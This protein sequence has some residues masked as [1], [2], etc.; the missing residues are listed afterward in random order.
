M[1]HES[2]PTHLHIARDGATLGEFDVDTVRS[3]VRDGRFRL[4]D[5]AWYD[6]ASGWMK[7]SQVP[8]GGLNAGPPTPPPPI[9]VAMAVP[10]ANSFAGTPEPIDNKLVPAILAT[11][12]CCL[13]IGIAAIMQASQVN[14]L[15]AQ[16]NR[17]AALE[18][19]RKATDYIG[20]SVG[21]GLLVALLY[22]AVIVANV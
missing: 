10:A 9:P 16:G 8:I 1:A 6:G 17:S 19:S 15:L 13:P 2:T 11:L 22:F 5:D 18:A 7:L 20:Y 3:G 14:T 12:F 21:A 4:T